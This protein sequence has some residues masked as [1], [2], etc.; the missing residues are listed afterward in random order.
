MI[1]KRFL[2]NLNLLQPTG[3]K[4]KL[5]ASVTMTTVIFP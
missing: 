2:G 1:S 4:G 3:K 5:L